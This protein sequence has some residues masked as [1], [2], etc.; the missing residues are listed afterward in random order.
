MSTPWL[1]HGLIVAAVAIV[2]FEWLSCLITPH[3]DF[4]LHWDDGLRMRMGYFKPG[5][6]IPYPPAWAAV[7][8]PL[9]LL[10]L[11]PAKAAFFVIGVGA[12]VGLMWILNDLMKMAM[13]L[14]KGRHFWVVAATL[15]AGSRFIT[16]DLDDG[17]QNLFLFTL[18]WLGV[19]LFVKGRPWSGGASLGLAIALKCTAAIFVLYFLLKRQWAMAASAIMWT[20]LFFLVTPLPWLTPGE[21]TEHVTVWTK[22]LI[23]GMSEPDPSR[24]V[25]GDEPIAN[26]SLRPSLA[27]YLMHLPDGHLGRHPH[28]WY[29][30]FLQLS[31]R[32]AGLI[33]KGILL[34]GL[35][36]MGWLLRKPIA[37]VGQAFQPDANVRLESLTYVDDRLTLVRECAIV[38]VAMLL[39][40]PITWGQHCV[41]VLP[42]L[43][44]LI[45][46]IGSEVFEKRQTITW[47]ACVLA[48]IFLTNRA[49]IGKD[50]SLLME[51]YHISTFA[52]IGLL[53]AVV[54]SGRLRS[55]LAVVSQRM[56]PSLVAPATA[57]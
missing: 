5:R 53:A 54:F 57:A 48:P 7:H 32:Q 17:G 46:G 43:Y 51:S 13:P 40:S 16:R 4:M 27:R 33:I 49:F 35:L 9:S 34:A 23:Q 11:G 37:S 55:R 3:G 21:M 19:W 47:L 24:G 26:K 38:S 15:L 41:A 6:H 50:L 28:R 2:L 29:F 36:G 52:L 30:D 39:Y 25:L 8:A 20:A 1:K 42:G 10:P 22:N 12:L 45:R 18:A 56:L 14:A 31:P 44:F